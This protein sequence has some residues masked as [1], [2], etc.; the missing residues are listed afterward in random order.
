[1]SIKNIIYI[2][3]V[4]VNKIPSPWRETFQQLNQSPSPLSVCN[5]PDQESE[6]TP[7]TTSKYVIYWVNKDKS[8]LKSKG[9]IFLTLAKVSK[10]VDELSN[11]TLELSCLNQPA[12]QLHANM[13][14]ADWQIEL[15]LLVKKRWNPQLK[16]P[17]SRR[18]AKLHEPGTN[19]LNQLLQL[20][21][22][23]FD[24][25]HHLSQHYQHAADWFLHIIQEA[26]KLDTKIIIANTAKGKAPIIKEMRDIVAELKYGKNPVTETTSPHFHKLIEVG[27][28]LNQP[29][30]SNKSDWKAFLKSCCQYIQATEKPTCQET[31]VKDNKIVRRAPG[32][33]R[34]TYL[35]IDI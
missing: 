30:S 26:Q 18:L 28:S 3:P 33:G 32:P 31:F 23:C 25:K 1:M 27:L 19:L 20:C 35:L 13:V 9:S 5:F 24:S 10:F 34:R 29:Y 7:D 11:Y 16:I 6:H 22:S 15:T 8:G 4:P 17:I 2:P 21:I 14:D 12:L